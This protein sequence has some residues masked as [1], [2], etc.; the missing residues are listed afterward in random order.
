MPAVW[1]SCL[2]P[3]R[4]LRSLLHSSQPVAPASLTATVGG[5]TYDW[6]ALQAA[7]D[8]DSEV[9]NAYIIVG[10]ATDPDYLFAYEKGSFGIDRVTPLASA[11]KWFAGTLAMRMAQAGIVPLEDSMRPPL[12]F[13]TKIGTKRSEER[14]VGNEGDHA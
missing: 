14:R 6:T 12:A 10:N 4:S 11:S 5:Y 1:F 7:I 9:A 13:W 2:R 8:A 3:R